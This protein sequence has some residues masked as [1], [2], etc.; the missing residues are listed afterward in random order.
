MGPVTATQN[1]RVATAG[2]RFRRVLLR[3]E[4]AAVVAFVLLTVVF[5]IGSRIFLTT[6]T[7]VSVLSVASE[8][9]ITAV[10]MTLLMIGGYFDLSVGAI[11][12]LT[13]WVVVTLMNDYGLAAPIA[14]VLALAVAGCMGLINGLILIKA[15]INSFV[16]TLGT[17]LVYRG[18]LVAVTGGFPVTVKIPPVVKTA[19]AGPILPFGFQMS[20]FWFL[21]IVAIAT[22][23]LL[24]TRLGNW[25]QATGQNRLAARNLGVPVD[26]ITLLLFVQAAVLAGATGV[27]QVARFATV[28]AAR[29]QGIELQAIAV[30]VIGGTLLTGGYGSAIGTALG[31]VVFAEIGIGLVL[32]RVPGYYY[33]IVQGAIVIGA[34]S[35][36]TVV[37]KLIATAR[38]LTGLRRGEAMGTPPANA[39]V[40]ARLKDSED[41][42]ITAT[43]EETTDGKE[44][45]P[46]G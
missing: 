34:V 20:L 8:L 1:R 39:A 18:I 24:R 43:V 42:G 16:V 6:D 10:G 35:M 4:P 12:G 46:N 31:A 22:V 9:G 15:R 2:E 44:E 36:N 27:I 40:A 17:M 45:A 33:L 23:L 11:L 29:G 37:T 14:F 32:N 21:L 13:S 25:I 28:D 7:F 19:L 5:S 3:P 26:R 41:Y 38:P 30:S